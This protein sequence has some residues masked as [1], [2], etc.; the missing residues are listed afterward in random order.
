MQNRHETGQQPKEQTDGNK[1]QQIGDRRIDQKCQGL[2]DLQQN[3]HELQP[4]H[5]RERFLVNDIALLERF[6][7]IQNVGSITPGE[8]QSAACNGE[9]EKLLHGACLEFIRYHIHLLEE[10]ALA[11]PLA[12]VPVTHMLAGCKHWH[13]RLAATYPYAE[14]TKAQELHND[15]VTVS[16]KKRKFQ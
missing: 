4:C 15:Y 5:Q 10:A 6:F 7:R 2:D 11:T 8:H 1:A 14:L 16:A 12:I 13:K 3:E 9:R